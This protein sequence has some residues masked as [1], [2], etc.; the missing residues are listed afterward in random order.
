[1]WLDELWFQVQSTTHLFMASSI[2][3]RDRL[4]WRK[5]GN[6]LH[7]PFRFWKVATAIN[8]KW[9]RTRCWTE[10]NH[11]PVTTRQLYA[12]LC[13]WSPHDQELATDFKINLKSEPMQQRYTWHMSLPLFFW[14]DRFWCRVTGLPGPKP[15]PHTAFGISKEIKDILANTSYFIHNLIFF[16][17]FNYFFLLIQ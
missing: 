5:T 9:L 8:R 6:R 7:A 4:K 12:K 15:R 10:S 17:A 1:M 2:E 14:Y 16:F 3:T 11:W 13:N